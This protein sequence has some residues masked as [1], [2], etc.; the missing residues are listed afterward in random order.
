MYHPILNLKELIKKGRMHTTSAKIKFNIIQI[1]AGG[2]GGYLVQRLS[3]LLY[4]LNSSDTLPFT[5]TLVDGDRVEENNLMRQPFIAQ[6]LD[7]PKAQV[8]AERYDN[9]YGIPIFYKNSY[10]ESAED[11]I[12]LIPEEYSIF[13]ESIPVIIGCVDNNATRK[14]IHEVFEEWSDIIYIDSGIDA[15]DLDGSPDSGYSGQVVCGLKINNTTYLEPVGKVYSNI[16]EDL[17]TRLPTQACGEQVVYYPQRMQT[18]EVAA[19]VMAGYL[20]TLLSDGEIVSHY[21]NFNARTM[22]IRPT[23]LEKEMVLI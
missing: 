18:N 16:L 8:L 12:Q 3:K 13:H 21:T 4:A 9:A 17:D 10:I 19:I 2:N 23:Y 7:L 11:I 14:L 6:D 20:N 22:M 15:V 1:G 5:Y